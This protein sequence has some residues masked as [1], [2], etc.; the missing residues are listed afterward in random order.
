[1]RL[2]GGKSFG[3]RMG[4]NIDIFTYTKKPYTIYQIIAILFLLSILISFLMVHT[5]PQCVLS[6]LMLIDSNLVA[7]HESLCMG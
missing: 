5:L 4:L 1:M 7:W 2:S 3:T 6:M